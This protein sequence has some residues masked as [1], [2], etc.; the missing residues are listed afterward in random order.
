MLH[1]ILF[2]KYDLGSILYYYKVLVKFNYITKENSMKILSIIVIGLYCI[3]TYPMDVN[4]QMP[5][6]GSFNIDLFSI[7]I[8]EQK[9]FQVK[10]FQNIVEEI[11]FSFLPQEIKE[12]EL[13][14]DAFVSALEFLP[15]HFCQD[16]ELIV[17]REVIRTFLM[18]PEIRQEDKYQMTIETWI[19][20]YFSL[21]VNKVKY[22][23]GNLLDEQIHMILNGI[24]DTIDTLPEKQHWSKH[25]KDIIDQ[26]VIKFN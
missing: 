3:T 12:D 19:A 15:P 25:I 23:K 26:K 9:R 2:C 11:D 10:Q 14:P 17:T 24:P 13:E 18:Y 7:T 16:D 8:G 4:T 6:A 22:H 5:Q 1:D 20:K 21:L